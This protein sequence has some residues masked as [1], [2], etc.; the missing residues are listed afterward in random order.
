[1]SLVSARFAVVVAMPNANKRRGDWAERVT[2]DVLQE[3]GFP[4][5]QKT[6]AGYQRDLGDLH[7]VPG[8]MVIAQVKNVRTPLWSSW[9]D[10]LHE[11]MANAEADH[12][13]LVW[14]RS[15]VGESRAKEWLA[16]MTLEQMALLLR[17][18]GYGSELT[19][20]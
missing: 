14:K 8:Q 16:V 20:E 6:R 19:G 5:C 12:G 11:Q 2:Q 10:D 1:M 7:L 3:L 9:L 15:G 4:W 17:R 18:A 13:F